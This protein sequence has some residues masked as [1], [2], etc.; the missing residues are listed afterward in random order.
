MPW[1]ESV[2]EHWH[3]VMDTVLTPTA[4]LEYCV[5][6]QHCSPKNAQAFGRTT[7]LLM[8]RSAHEQGEVSVRQPHKW[9]KTAVDFL[10]STRTW[11]PDALLKV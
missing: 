2:S 6:D 10:S 5:L 8:D 4:K 1:S 7:M 9:S 11:T 3:K